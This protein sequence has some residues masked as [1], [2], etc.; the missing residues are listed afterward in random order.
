MT[1]PDTTARAIIDDSLENVARLADR[2][3]YPR[4]AMERAHRLI[5]TVRH[6]VAVGHWIGAT[7]A[8]GLLRVMFGGVP[9]A[10]VRAEAL[11]D[12]KAALAAV[13]EGGIL[14]AMFAPG[15]LVPDLA[16][17]PRPQAAEA[18]R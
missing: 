1:R 10:S 13:D 2:Y 5:A 6:S 14:D 15:E 3:V 18:A 16:W 11:E 9:Q 4:P 17:F 12:I 8:L 7:D